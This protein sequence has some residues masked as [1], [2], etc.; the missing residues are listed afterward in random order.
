MLEHEADFTL[1]DVFGGYVLPVKQD[2][3]AVGVFQ[4]G[5]DA[6]E[7]GFAATGRAEQ[8]NEF[9]GGTL[10]LMFSARGTLR[11]VYLGFGW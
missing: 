9:A 5:D 1:P 11:S 10:R 2:I 8:G 6:Q 4:S 7:R 3:A